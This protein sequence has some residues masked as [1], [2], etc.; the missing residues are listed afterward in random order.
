MSERSAIQSV[1]LL[2]LTLMPI[3]AIAGPLDWSGYLSVEPRLFLE[4][5]LFEVQP[6]QRVSPSVVIAPE[7]RIEWGQGSHRFTFAP[8]WRFDADDSNRSHADLREAAWQYVNRSWTIQAGV[9]RV[10][11][12][13]TESRHLVDIVN[14][15]DLVEDIDEEDKLG[16]PLF[17]V[18]RWTN[19]GTFTVM[20]LP[21][22]RER[23]FPAD[24]ARLRG[25]I[26]IDTDRADYE[27]SAKDRRVDAALRW[28]HA[29]D[30]W[31]VGLSGFYGNAREPRLLPQLDSNNRP[32][33]TPRYD[34]I[35]QLGVDAQYT[36]NAW[37][38]KL[39]AIGRRGHGRPFG[40]V[41]AGVEYTVFNVGD[42]GADVGLLAEYLLDDRDSTA[43]PTLYNNDMFLG[44]RFALNDADDTSVLGGVFFDNSGSIAVIEAQ[45]RLGS[46]WKFEAEVRLFIGVDERDPLLSG[47]AQDSFVT[48]RLARYL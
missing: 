31:D 43:P 6:H 4:A 46:T 1:W 35:S 14:Q 24:D 5:P 39:E 28:S 34:V 27:S 37:L 40:A 44:L 23:T 42:R 45:R 15:T 20:L 11:W 8:Y 10:F 29:F 22:F 16:Q 12:G 47:F 13:V 3:T 18:E 19:T 7:L 41:V 17:S 2:A 9:S 38:W 21:G 26:P 33:L 48:L 30:N 32:V 36:N 25:A